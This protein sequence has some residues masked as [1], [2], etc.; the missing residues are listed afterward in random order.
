MDFY[1]NSDNNNNNNIIYV[2]ST[3]LI[4]VPW[5]LFN[6]IKLN[7]VQISREIKTIM[8]TDNTKARKL[9]QCQ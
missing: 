3:F 7:F 5:C 1:N 9:K 4:K 2:Y 6:E 8:Q